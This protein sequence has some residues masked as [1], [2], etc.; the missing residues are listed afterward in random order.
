[1]NDDGSKISIN[2]QSS[3]ADVIN[4]VLE[5]AEKLS[6]LLAREYRALM[7]QDILLIDSLNIEKN[8][9]L[10]TL[11][12]LEP[13]LR[14]VYNAAEVTEGEDVVRQLLE[15]CSEQNTRNHSL[16]LVVIDQNRKSLSLLRNVLK[17]DQTSVYSPDGELN[18]DKSKRYLGSA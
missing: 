16:V 2:T 13:H 6:V 14:M 3:S 17:L 18:A 8:T 4:S 9:V 10:N 11:T 5:N 15:L 1:M 7:E 12:E